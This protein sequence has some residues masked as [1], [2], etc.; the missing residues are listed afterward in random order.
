MRRRLRKLLENEHFAIVV[1][2]FIVISLISF[3]I[4]TLP[5]LSAITRIFLYWTELV[6]VG[7]FTVEYLMRFMAEQRAR[8][9]VFS[10]FGVVDL[11]AI[12]PFYLT[13][14][15]DL[16][17]LRSLRFLRAFQLLKLTR[18]NRAARRLRL[19]VKLVREDLIL[20]GFLSL[21]IMFLSSVGIYYCEKDSQPEVFSS[22]FH[23][24]W[25][26]VATLTTVGY[27]DI[28]PVTAGGKF[29]TFCVLVVSLGIVAMPAG[30][31]ASSLS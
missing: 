7:F 2:A 26:S 5:D 13:T 27:G 25:W 18:Y 1:Q 16:R 14:G 15:L 19:A 10:F 11:L 29:F 24:M 17:A 20:F 28:Y 21:I 4:E 8:D 3:C 23:S 6:T 12:A 9:Y 22:I 31:L 30:L